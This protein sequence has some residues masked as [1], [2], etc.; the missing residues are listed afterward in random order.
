MACLA[1][2]NF[3]VALAHEAHE[4]SRRAGA[5][6]EKPASAPT[7]ALCRVAQMGMLRILTN[8]SWLKAE[9]RSAA[10][11]WA[12]WDALLSDDRFVFL[13]EPVGLEREWRRLTGELA[14]TRAV[15]TDSYLAA[16]ALAADLPVL[17]FDRAFG[18][19]LAGGQRLRIEVPA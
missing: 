8:R 18:T 13:D 9:V 14:T 15:E 17:T 10:E 4:H 3:L 7:I 16:F 1:D 19:G 12:A 11:V 5:W 6:L 2:V